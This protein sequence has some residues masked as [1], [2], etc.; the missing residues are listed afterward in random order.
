MATLKILPGIEDLLRHS[1][2]IERLTYDRI[3]AKLK[4]EYPG[5]RGLSA[6]S[7]RRFCLSEGIH[8][9]SRLNCN[10]LDRVVVGCIHRVS[11]AKVAR[12]L[13]NN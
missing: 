13:L 5:V 12:H 7:V 3:S 4:R 8:K 10:N 11:L 9:T 6:R 1:L 2:L